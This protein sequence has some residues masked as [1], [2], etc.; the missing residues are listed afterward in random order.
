MSNVREHYSN[1]LA[2]HYTW[3]FGVSLETKV[4]EQKELLAAVLG[5]RRGCAV[6]LGCGPGF[7][8]LALAELGWG[9]IFSID[10]SAEL[11]EELKAHRG[12]YPIQTCLGDML[13]LRG[14]VRDG[15]AAAI[16]CMGDT[17]THLENKEAVRDL[18]ASVQLSLA[19]EG[20]FVITYRDLTVELTGVDRFL[21]VRADEE[22]IMTCFL[23]YQSPE[24]VMVHDLIHTKNDGEWS[25]HKSCY[26]K[27][28]LSSA[29][30]VE[31]LRDAGLAILSHGPVGRMTQIVAAK[32]V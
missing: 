19:P 10:T 2:K 23:E 14:Y 5:T 21:P 13:Q 15:A 20:V 9:P 8:S 32:T 17:L 30:V 7:Q 12:A 3:M 11:L 28:R 16:L 4:A 25:L 24:T 22:K 18:F 31:A 29:W 26:R 27:L 1:L 6:D